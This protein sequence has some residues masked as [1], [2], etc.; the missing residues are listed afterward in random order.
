V[1]SGTNAIAIF[2]TQSGET[3]DTTAAQRAA[4]QAGYQTIAI[5]NVVGSTIANE[6]DAVMY[7]FAGKERAIPATKSFTSQLAALYLIAL[8]LAS[9]KRTCTSEVFFRRAGELADVADHLEAAL[10]Q[11]EKDARMIASRL[12][13]HHEWVLL[14]RGVHFPVALEGAL[15]LKETSYIH[16]EGFPSG[17]FRHGPAAVLDGSQVV[18]GVIGH[19][20]RVPASV[21]RYEK[22]LEVLD[23]IAPI[24]GLLVLIAAAADTNV[25]SRTTNVIFVPQVSEFMLPILET[26]ALQLLAY[27]A[28]IGRNLDVDRPRN[29]VKSVQVD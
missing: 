6:A 19:D 9:A 10:P 21:A 29:L 5:T 4:H 17:E 27:H 7:T 22:S 14:G 26:V 3:A 1:A 18:L 15:K 20:P 13:D 23:D 8:M 28:A 2:I 16:A 12:C 25:V 11:I 24:T